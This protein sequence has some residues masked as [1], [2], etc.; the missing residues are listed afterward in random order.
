MIQ[1]NDIEA[2]HPSSRPF[3]IHQD[4]DLTGTATGDDEVRSYCALPSTEAIKIPAGQGRP[5]SDFQ[6]RWTL[7]GVTGMTYFPRQVCRWPI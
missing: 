3:V 4:T 7:N 1:L 5:Q 6:F 2:A